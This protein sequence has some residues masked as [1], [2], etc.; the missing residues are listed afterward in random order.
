MCHHLVSLPARLAC[1]PVLQ[2][3]YI[4]TPVGE[5]PHPILKVSS[6]PKKIQQ[7]LKLRSTL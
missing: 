5:I 6:P 4:Q 3:G 2:H 7:S 1:K